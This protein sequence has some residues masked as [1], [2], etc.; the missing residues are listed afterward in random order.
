MQFQQGPVTQRVGNRFLDQLC[1]LGWRHHRPIVVILHVLPGAF[2][3]TVKCQGS[4]PSDAT[5]GLWLAHWHPM[6]ATDDAGRNL[7]KPEI[8]L[9]LS[10]LLAT[11]EGLRADG[12]IPPAMAWPL[13]RVMR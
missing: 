7:R 5:A 12:G 2:G 10:E 9:A 6:A 8:R 3:V 13:C 1:P 11:M 4:S